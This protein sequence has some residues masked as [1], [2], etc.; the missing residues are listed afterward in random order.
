MMNLVIGWNVLLVIY[1]KE[2]IY[3][4]IKLCQLIERELL[5]L[6]H[7]TKGCHKPSMNQ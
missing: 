1:K 3:L 2:G 6:S 7:N 4:P 5:T